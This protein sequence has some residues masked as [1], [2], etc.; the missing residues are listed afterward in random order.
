MCSLCPFLDLLCFFGCFSSFLSSDEGMLL[1]LM[2]IS[3][4]AIFFSSSVFADNGFRES[5]SLLSFD[6]SISLISFGIS[7]L[8]FSSGVSFILSLF[9]SLIISL[10]SSSLVVGVISLS[11]SLLSS[12]IIS[13]F[14]SSLVVGAISL[15]P[16]FFYGFYLQAFYF[17][18]LY[19]LYYLL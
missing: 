16:F 2:L 9:S 14:S 15:C 3:S 5:C 10:F 4:L 13:L 6:F 1:S 7:S 8:S 12:L 18:L 17:L 11:L 19:H